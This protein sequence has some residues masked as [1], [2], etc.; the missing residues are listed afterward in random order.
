MSLRYEHVIFDL[1]GTLVD[2]LA[3]LTIAVN[4]VRGVLGTG[5]LASDEVRA[6]V[7]EG[8]R[9]LITR[10]LG[11][12]HADRVEEGLGEFFAFYGAHLLDH[13]GPYPGIPAL[14]SAL[15]ARGSRC[16]V[17]TNKPEA[18]SRRILEGLGLLTF[19]DMVV[20]GDSLPTRKPD[21]AG[22]AH[23]AQRT[24]VPLARTLLVGDSEIDARTAAA[25]GVAFC[26]VTWG[27][28]PDDV[29][30]AAP[31]WTIHAPAELLRVVTEE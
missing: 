15:R 11:S 8:A 25:A 26:G 2:T 22:V 14:L 21:P 23:I 13:T 28:A 3:D 7:G 19:L 31:A 5:P 16:S 30:R 24:N 6:H 27:F 17:L 4:H 12:E 1:D 18:M 9:L 20:G 29:R 10:A